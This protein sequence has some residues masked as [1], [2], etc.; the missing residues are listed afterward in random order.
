VVALNVVCWT[1]VF[2]GWE[3]MALF[4]LTLVVQHND[5]HA[6]PRRKLAALMV[7]STLFVLSCGDGVWDTAC[8]LVAAAVIYQFKHLIF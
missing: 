3:L 2:L 8:T 4:L 7:A 1:L 6:V 5:M